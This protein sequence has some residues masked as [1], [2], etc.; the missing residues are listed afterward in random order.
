MADRFQ[1]EAIIKTCWLGCSFTWGE[2]FDDLDREQYIYDRVVSKE[3]GWHH[4]NQAKSGASNHMIFLA[5]AQNLLSKQH[6]RVFVQWSALS[7]IWLFPGPDA[8][9]FV[10]DQR[11]P[12]FTYRDLH[13]TAKDK[14]KLNNLLLLLNHDYHNIL[15]LIDYCCILENLAQHVGQDVIFINGLVPWTR[16]LDSDIANDDLSASMT[17][18]TKCLLDFDHRDDAEMISAFKILRAKFKTL[19]QHLWVNLF[20][21]MHDHM[22]DTGPLGHHPGV[23]SNRQMADRIID[24]LINFQGAKNA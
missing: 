12:D 18:Y 2:G 9:Y 23:Q 19:S 11:H 3:M 7:R 6:D 10:N 24:F 1:S 22:I 17:A 8:Q 5:A 4:N 16:D 21:S 14:K 13:I 20:D 15:H